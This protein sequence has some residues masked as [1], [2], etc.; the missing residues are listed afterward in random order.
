MLQ[1]AIT[2]KFCNRIISFQ[3]EPGGKSMK[4]DSAKRL[5]GKSLWVSALGLMVLAAPIQEAF[6]QIEEIV[7]TSRRYEERI[8]DAPLAVAV[9]TSEFLDENG[10]LTVQDVL[11]LSPGSEWGQFAKA[12]PRLTMRGISGN[13]YGNA[14]LEHAVSVVSDGVPV[15]KAFMMTLPVY[16]QERVEVLRGPQGTTFGRNAT[17]GM[18]HFISARPSQEGSADIEVSAGDRDLFAINGHF[19]GSL[20]DTVSGRIAINYSD[21]PGPMDDEA[22]GDPL[23]YSENTSIRASLLFEPS[24]TFSAYVKAE[25]MED[26]EFPTVRRG[27]DLDVQW[28]NGNYGSY[29]SNSDPWKAT[30]SPDPDGAPWVVERE[31]INLTAELNW[32]LSNDVS[33]TSIT[34]YLDGDHYS[35]SDAFGT[36]Y[37]I[38][39]QL[40]WNDASIFSQEFR[41]DNQ[42]SGNKFRWLVG[43]SYLTDEEHRIDKN[44]SEPLRGNCNSTDPTGCGRNSILITDGVNN[45]DAFGVFGELTFDL[46]DSL[47]L[48]V[49]ARYSEDSRD[50]NMEVTGW[51]AEGGLGGIGL[52]NPDPTKDCNAIQDAGTT[53]GFCGTE[54][55]PVGYDGKVSDSWDDVSPKVSLTWAINDNNNLYALYS[56]GFK[57]GGFQQ[58]ARWRDALDLVLDAEESTNIELG[59]KG[60][61]D[62]IVFAVTYFQQ[63]QTGIHTGNL[64]AVGSSQSNLLV[65][66]KGVENEGF[67]FEATWAP[68]DSLTLGGNIALYD[69]KFANG[70][71]IN[72]AQAADGTITGGEDVSGQIPA[73]NVKESAYLFASYD[74]AFAS[75]ANLRLRADVIKRDA[76]WGQNGARNR[77]GRN[78]NDDGLMYLRPSQT[79]PGL[80]A[81]WTSA[82]GNISFSVWGRNLDDD[83]DYINYG[84]G[85]GYVYLW[86][87][88]DPA[89]DA[90]RARPM[91]STGR[92]QVGATFKYNF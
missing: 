12:Q 67:E 19:N 43:A 34:G 53:P 75:G 76:I 79:K 36:P 61:Y 72:G 71:I 83:P 65:N 63:E 38:R 17:L 6:A 9:M 45:T 57:G 77:G 48:V 31:M 47:T 60:S 87:P 25:Y 8:T 86:G 26:E 29:V 40:V 64:V 82:E 41:L 59:W 1:N 81:E 44:E 56:E 27:G 70:T 3:Y 54:A 13:S 52:D 30:L 10:V 78:L 18:M 7:V 21:T 74:I 4:N 16:D 15:T 66:A 58:D 46:S 55:N 14:S 39:D 69:P 37:D 92:K 90:V 91:G 89:V 73:N 35:N 24:D 28:L 20:S 49:G 80:R 2:S 51:G 32:S 11:N 68:T 23:D 42:A 22:S 5:S 85:F 33:L 50:L 62:N 88:G 84:P